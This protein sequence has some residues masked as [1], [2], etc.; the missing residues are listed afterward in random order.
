M[1]D[2]FQFFKK[3]GFLGILGP[4]LCGI[5][6]TIRIG[7]EMLC[8]PYAGFFQKKEYQ[9]VATSKLLYSPDIGDDGRYLTC[10]VLAKGRMEESLEDTWEIKVLCK[11]SLILLTSEINM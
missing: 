11:D 7:R 5:G 3:I 8:L 9:G 2:F 4:P 6:A 1:D 10:R